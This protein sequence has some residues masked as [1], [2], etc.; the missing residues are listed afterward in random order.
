[1]IGSALIFKAIARDGDYM[2]GALIFADQPCADDGALILADAAKR[3]IA[4][5]N[6]FAQRFQPGDGFGLQAAI[7]EFLNAIGEAAFQKAPV[8]GWR[9]GAKEA[10]PLLLQI[11]DIGAWQRGK[12]GWYVLL[13][14]P[15]S[16]LW[17]ERAFD[18][19]R[20]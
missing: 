4:A 18:K 1:M 7:G 9:F 19:L 10:A 14:D 6:L 2:L 11:A 8:V 13:R 20:R 15:C 3:D 5:I 12:P 17:G 16:R